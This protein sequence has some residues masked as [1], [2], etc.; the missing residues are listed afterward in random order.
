M[1]LD[2]FSAAPIDTEVALL[3][4]SSGYQTLLQV[5]QYLESVASQ[6]WSD[7]VDGALLTLNA[8]QKRRQVLELTATSL[9]DGEDIEENMQR[10]STLTPSSMEQAYDRRTTDEGLSLLNR[11][12]L[13]AS[14]NAA[15]SLYRLACVS[16]S[17]GFV[18]TPSSSSQT[19]PTDTA[20]LPLPATPV[21]LQT[22]PEQLFSVHYRA[23]SECCL[24]AASLPLQGV[25][26]GNCH[27]SWPSAVQMR[28][29]NLMRLWR[30]RA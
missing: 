9:R 14:V 23:R 5:S 19:N 2:C 28:R 6:S 17:P 1:L 8:S 20:P 12:G 25:P 30:S 26:P 13:L 15:L 27:L 22:G 16:H 18:P 4:T 10:F 29:G 11:Y 7:A 24:L 3:L 21:A